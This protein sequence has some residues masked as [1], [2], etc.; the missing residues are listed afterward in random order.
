LN[1]KY[2]SLD[3]ANVYITLVLR[4]KKMKER[5]LMNNFYNIVNKINFV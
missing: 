2:V 5:E 3:V 1:N 4:S